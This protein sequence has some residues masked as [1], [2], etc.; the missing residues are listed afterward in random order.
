MTSVSVPKTMKG[1]QA[2]NFGGPEVLQ[3][4][5]DLPVPT[6]RG[7]EILV[8]NEFIGVN[9]VDV[10]VLLFFFSVFS[11][12]L[13]EEEIQISGHYLINSLIPDTGASV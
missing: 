4:K 10:L 13:Y 3:Y 12:F 11:S 1:V 9:Y 7:G 2:T 6:P 5:T 8:K